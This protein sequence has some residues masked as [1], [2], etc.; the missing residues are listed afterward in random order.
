MFLRIYKVVRL[1][2]IKEINDFILNLSNLKYGLI[3]GYV[4]RVD[5]KNMGRG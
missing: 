4:R 5:G 1:L 2:I 3:Q